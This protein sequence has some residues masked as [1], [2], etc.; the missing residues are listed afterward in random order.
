MTVTKHRSAGFTL[1]ELVV[2]ISILAILAAFALPR[3]AE[4]SDQAHRASIQ[5]T[6]GAFSSAVALSRAQWVANGAPGAIT[7]LE[8]FGAENVD[9]SEDGW[10]ISVGND[11]ATVAAMGP[12]DCADLWA[13]LMQSNAPSIGTTADQ[14][15]YTAS[16]PSSGVCQYDYNLNNGTD[17]IIY[18]ADTGDVATTIN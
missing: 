8:N 3:F 13:G 1:I 11:R 17:N 9:M 6:S 4:L 5:G 15:D 12:G 18:D 2:V 16:L 10:P 14:N 7:N